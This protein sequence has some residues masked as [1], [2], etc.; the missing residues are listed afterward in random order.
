MKERKENKEEILLEP[1]TKHISL[2]TGEEVH[3]RGVYLGM[4]E[5]CNVPQYRCPFSCLRT[6]MG[7]LCTP[8]GLGPSFLLLCHSHSALL[9]W[10]EALRNHCGVN[11]WHSSEVG[12]M[13]SLFWRWAVIISVSASATHTHLNHTGLL[14]KL[15][16]AFLLFFSFF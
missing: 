13:A 6:W 14:C 8:C 2:E 7:V 3:I 10:N 5:K 9:C 1:W 15:L 16:F 11:E 12:L 4:S